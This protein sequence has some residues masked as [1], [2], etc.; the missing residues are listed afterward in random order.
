MRKAINPST[1]IPLAGLEIYRSEF[2]TA[3]LE[4]LAVVKSAMVI[5]DYL[6]VEKLAHKWRGFS[7]PYGFGT[8]GILSEELE[9]YAVLFDQSQCVSIIEEI[10]SYLFA[11]KKRDDLIS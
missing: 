6:T 9:E 8:L 3:R 5:Q 4:E 7:A 10:E 1:E 11:V 2:L